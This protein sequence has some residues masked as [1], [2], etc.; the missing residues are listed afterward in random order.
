MASTQQLKRRIG[1]VK[2][3]KQITKAMELVAASKMRRAQENAARSRDYRNLA[4]QI[5]TRLR[6]LTDVS[7]H[8]LYNQR[9]VKTRLHIVV[10]SDRGLA[11]AYNSNIFRQFAKELQA[12][13]DQGIVSQAIVVGKQIS[14]FASRLEQCEVV[15]AYHDFS[16]HPTANDIRPILSTIIELFEAKTV[17]AIDIIYTDFISSIRQDVVVDRLLPAAFQ[18]VAVPADL[19]QATFEPS[20]R[21]VLESVT[22][23]LIESQLSQALLEAQASE[24]SMRMMA[25]KSATDNANDLIDDLTLAF[26][27]ARQAGITQELA[28]ITGGAEAIQ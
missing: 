15:A 1:S 2:N 3:T 4:R 18:E 24:H 28:E 5:L 11:G 26:N 20:A 19:E 27:T 9:T 13:K 17:D 16:E 6:E 7:K 25:M 23:R 12:D 21:A 22:T 14:Q 8:P 10:A